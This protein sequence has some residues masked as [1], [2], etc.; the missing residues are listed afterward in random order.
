MVRYIVG[1]DRYNNAVENDGQMS[2][3]SPLNLLV[4]VILG[5]SLFIHYY[6]ECISI[7]K[8]IYFNIL[9]IMPFSINVD[10]SIDYNLIAYS[11]KISCRC[12]IQLFPHVKKKSYVLPK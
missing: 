10:N 8:T 3:Q 12:K 5:E 2:L 1:G 6:M 9:K 4:V 7:Y 11:H